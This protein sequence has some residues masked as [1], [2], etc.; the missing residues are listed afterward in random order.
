MITMESRIN[1]PYK[2]C[3]S[4]YKTAREICEHLESVGGG[5][6]DAGVIRIALNEGWIP[7]PR[8]IMWPNGEF[9]VL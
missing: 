3:K 7:M 8:N 4:E 5:K 2:L 1:D 9:V 6:V